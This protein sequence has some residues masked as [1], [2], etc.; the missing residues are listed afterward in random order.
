MNNRTYI[1]ALKHF[2]RI[3]NTRGVAYKR[4]GPLY[5]GGY[6]LADDISERDYFISCGIGNNLEWNAEFL[7]EECQDLNFKKVDM[8]DIAPQYRK[9]SISNYEYYQKEL[10][11][12]YG[13]AEMIS[14]IS[15]NHS[16]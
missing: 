12:N 13:L 7:M 3:Y 2:L 5:D 10:G 4:F 11:K 16:A 9:F 1:E 14:N 6:I 15:E 8:Y